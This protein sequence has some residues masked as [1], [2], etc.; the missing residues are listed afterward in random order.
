MRIVTEMQIKT[1]DG[2]ELEINSLGSTFV[3]VYNP[4]ID[5]PMLRGQD[6]VTL[7]DLRNGVAA[8]E[9]H[10]ILLAGVEQTFDGDMDFLVDEIEPQD[11]Q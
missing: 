8:G 3:V 4:W 2:L 11:L 9:I 5:G 7:N 10:S 1:S 6:E